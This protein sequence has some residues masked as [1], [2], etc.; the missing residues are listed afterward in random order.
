MAGKT[1]AELKRDRQRLSRS[2]FRVNAFLV[3]S[4]FFLAGLLGLVAPEFI[5]LLLGE[6]WLPMLGVFRLML[7]FTLFDPIKSTVARLFIAVG[8]PEQVVKA[9]FIQLLVLLGGL[10]FLGSPL[11]ITG[12]ALAVDLMLVVGI[13]I[14]L[15]Q[16]RPFVDFSPIRL[17]FG[18]GLALT[19]GLIAASV[20]GGRPEIADVDWQTG[21]AKFVVFSSI[22]GVILLALERRQF[23]EILLFLRN[24]IF[25][26]RASS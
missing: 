11:G 15:W 2:F 23:S 18:P 26:T 12:V 10:Y 17:F 1:Y 13:V 24:R 9:R 5:H 6:K 3:R 22:Y 20:A 25:R 4:G 16:A 19:V 21:L 14:L 8:K 7:V